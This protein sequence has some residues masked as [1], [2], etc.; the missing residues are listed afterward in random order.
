MLILSW[1]LLTKS[2]LALLSVSRSWHAAMANPGVHMRIP[3]GDSL[4]VGL[5]APRLQAP[6]LN[7]IPALEPMG[8]T[9]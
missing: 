6:I 1:Q 8:E 4:L 3:P 9:W 7:A 5:A 2:K